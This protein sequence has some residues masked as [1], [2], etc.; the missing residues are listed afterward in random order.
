MISF[1][2]LKSLSRG[3]TFQHCCTTFVDPTMLEHV[4]PMLDDVLTTIFVKLMF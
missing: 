3:Y 4:G 1:L 2:F